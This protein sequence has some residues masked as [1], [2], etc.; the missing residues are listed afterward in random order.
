MSQLKPKSGPGKR[1]IFAAG[2]KNAVL[3][4]P[5]AHNKTLGTPFSLF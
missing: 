3:L 1:Q 2:G 5:Q 4:G